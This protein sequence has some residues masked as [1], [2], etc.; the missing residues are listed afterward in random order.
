MKRHILVG[1]LALF[2]ALPGRAEQ[3]HS[4]VFYQPTF[5]ANAGVEDSWVGK[6]VMTKKAGVKIRD[7]NAQDRPVDLTTLEEDEVYTVL[8]D[9]DSLIMVKHGSVGGWFPKEDA[10]L[11]EEAEEYFTRIIQGQPKDDHAWGCRGSKWRTKGEWDKAINDLNEAIR[12][13]PTKVAWYTSRAMAYHKKKDFD[14]AIA[15]CA[16]AIRLDPKL[17]LVFKMRG[18]VY[19][20]KKDFGLAIIDIT[21]AIQLD[22][23]DDLALKYQIR[24]LLFIKMHDYVRAIADLTEA[25]RLDPNNLQAYYGRGIAYVMKKDYDH[26]IADQTKAIGLDP[27]DSMG[28]MGRGLVYTFT[29]EYDRAISDYNEAIVLDPKNAELYSGRGAAFRKKNEYDRAIADYTEAVRLDP[30]NETGFMGLAWIWATCPKDDLRNARKAVEYGEKACELDGWKDARSL[31]VLAAAYAAAGRFDDA[32]KWQKLALA[33]PNLDKSRRDE[34]RQ[35]LNI[36]E[37]GKP[38][39]EK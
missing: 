27:K 20:D 32:V 8:K 1:F 2:A 31:E 36:F 4:Q 11:F 25:I 28:Y 39:R 5:E 3:P 9:R 22:P 38:Y 23:N 7:S 17:G 15:D 12:I 14:R 16:E 21:K 30:K 6:K 10:V 26:A 24:G 34:A 18:I 35:R 13:N 33:N 37:L 19:A 29:K